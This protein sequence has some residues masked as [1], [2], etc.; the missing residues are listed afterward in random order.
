MIAS[1]TVRVAIPNNSSKQAAANLE[2]EESST[3]IVPP[4][5]GS[6][7]SIPSGPVDTNSEENQQSKR[8]IELKVGAT[9]THVTPDFAPWITRNKLNDHLHE[10]V[11]TVQSEKAKLFRIDTHGLVAF[12]DVNEKLKEMTITSKKLDE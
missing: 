12:K 1:G 6:A 10:L 9:I 2:A 3:T 4:V 5:P 7:S 11:Y 8:S